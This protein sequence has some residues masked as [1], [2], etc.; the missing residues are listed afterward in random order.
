VA[1]YAAEPVPASI[2]SEVAEYLMRQLIGIQNALRNSSIVMEFSEVPERP[3]VGAIINVN[4]PND[5]LKN[6][7]WVCER[8]LGSESQGEGVWKRLVTEVP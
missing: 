5:N 2:D 8:E 7:F 6:G 4:D 3:I 1:N